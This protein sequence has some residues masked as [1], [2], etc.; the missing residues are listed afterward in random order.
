[1]VLSHLSNSHNIT[2]SRNL[3]RNHKRNHNIRS[4]AIM[5]NKDMLRLSKDIP[6][7]EDTLSKVDMLRNHKRKRKRH[8]DMR[9]LSRDIH[10]RIKGNTSINHSSLN[11][12]HNSL[13]KH[14][15]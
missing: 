15:W 3:K 13:H 11:S 9:W 2:L 5:H 12:Q 8:Q 10:L 1:M 14:V 6:N 4:K 7:K